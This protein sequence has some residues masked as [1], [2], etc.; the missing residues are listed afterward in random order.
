MHNNDNSKSLLSAKNALYT[1]LSVSHLLNL[2]NL[3]NNPMN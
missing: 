3:Y 2:F 1:I